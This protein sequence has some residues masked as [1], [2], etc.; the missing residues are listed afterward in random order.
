MTLRTLSRP[1]VFQMILSNPP[2]NVIDGT[3]MNEVLGQLGKLRES[4][5]L[6]RYV[7][8]RSDVPKRFSAG[9][10][11]PEHEPK[12]APEMIRLFHRMILEWARL[13]QVTMAAVSGYAYGGAAEWL[14]V[15]DR[16]FATP[17]SSI[18]FPEIRLGFFPPVAAILLPTILAPPLARAM[19]LGGR[20]PP[21]K[22]WVDMGWPMELIDEEHI[23][24]ALD[25]SVTE[26]EQF[27]RPV[28]SLTHR[29]MKS[30]DLDEFEKRLHKAEEVFINEL[31]TLEDP[32]EGIQA[33]MEK[34]EPVWKHS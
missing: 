1:P 27:S 8:L 30:F 4:A 2:A 16:V 19:V 13:P 25:K 9:V 14:L 31:L 18:G 17:D 23:D 12:S 32:A 28:I 6:H 29:L 10:S 3:L 11:I 34:R 21:S 5:D 26:L 33:F 24:E 22:V 15:C 7:I 20:T